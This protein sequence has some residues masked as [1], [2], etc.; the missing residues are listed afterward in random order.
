M[1]NNGQPF[2]VRPA[3]QLYLLADPGQAVIDAHATP[4]E[5]HAAISG[6]V[7][8]HGGA[9][10]DGNELPGYGQTIEDGQHSAWLPRGGMLKN[11][12]RFHSLEKPEILAL[13][14]LRDCLVEATK[15]GFLHMAEVI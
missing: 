9:V 5:D 1:P 7:R 2:L 11:R 3:N 4:H 6:R 12:Y 13:F 8:R 10:H 15:L 14:P